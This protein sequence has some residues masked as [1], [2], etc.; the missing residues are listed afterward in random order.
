MGGPEP[1]SGFI[2]FI[3]ADALDVVK[4][5]FSDSHPDQRLKSLQTG[6]PSR[7]SL[8]AFVEGS[9][10]EER[11]L[12]RIFSNLRTHGEWFRL[13][14]VV[15]FLVTAIGGCNGLTPRQLFDRAME[16]IEAGA[17][18]HELDYFEMP[19]GAPF[20]GAER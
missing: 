11:H 10:R 12:H 19:L 18:E 17:D 5:G 8:L 9:Q 13:E 3:A 7:L 6:C 2:Y 15:R 16:R 4:I 14:G 1:M 20:R